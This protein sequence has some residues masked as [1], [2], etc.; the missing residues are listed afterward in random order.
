MTQ[1][2]SILHHI[3]HQFH[4]RRKL[5]FAVS[6]VLCIAMLGINHVAIASYVEM[7]IVKSNLLHNVRCNVHDFDTFCPKV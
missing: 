2:N 5:Y 6:V 1:Y 3:C 7:C 4:K